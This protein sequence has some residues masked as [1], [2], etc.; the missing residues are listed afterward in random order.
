MRILSLFF[1]LLVANP[2]SAVEAIVKD[3]D[4]IQIG[5]VAYKLA[6]LDAPEVDQPC[7]DEHADNWACGVE[8][9]DQL[10]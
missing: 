7:V 5:N 6:G 1:L 8:A 9:R 4:T 3:G 10:V 2:A